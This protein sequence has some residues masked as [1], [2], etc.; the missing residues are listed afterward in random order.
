[1]AA[2]VAGLAGPQAH[3]QPLPPEPRPAERAERTDR[4]SH[5]PRDE[6]PQV[7]AATAEA[8]AALR[9]EVERASINRHMTVGEFVRRVHAEEDLTRAL[10]RA[11]MVG[12]PRWVDNDTCEVQLEMSGSRVGHILEQIGATSPDSPV[13]AEDL[14]VL[15]IAWRRKTF[16]GVGSSTSLARVEKVRPRDTGWSQVT[17]AERSKAIATAKDDAIGRVID[18]IKPIALTKDT[19]VGDA[20]QVNPAVR[21]DVEEWLAVR[22][23]TRLEFRRDQ[24]VELTMAGTP[25]GLAEALRRSIIKTDLPQPANEAGWAAVRADFERKMANPIGRASVIPGGSGGG[26]TTEKTGVAAGNDAPPPKGVVPAAASSVVSRPPPR[27][28]LG[29]T[30]DWTSERLEAE[31]VADVPDFKL[32]SAR[33]AE[34]E[35]RRKLLDRINGLEL[36]NK[37][38]VGKAAEQNPR[39]R[40]A[41][42]HALDKARVAKTDYYNKKGVAVVV[43]MDLQ[44]LWDA[45]KTA[46]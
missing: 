30:P 14:S 1:M 29:R 2:A 9:D 8:V 3:A 32:K 11:E 7:Q 19:T 37:V 13:K 23:V 22:P 45:L 21:K 38:T 28:S 25:T 16:S 43:R 35:A 18:S 17:D 5:D 10:Q 4:I 34:A 46:E 12:G 26:A 33:E 6:R 27:F 41:V 40:D 31:G 15:P 39:V 42:N 24:Q 44:D 20:M 36:S